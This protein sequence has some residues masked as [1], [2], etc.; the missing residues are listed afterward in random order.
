MKRRRRKPSVLKRLDIIRGIRRV[1]GLRVPS[2]RDYLNKRELTHL[3]A[4][5]SSR[6]EKARAK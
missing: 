2:R 5:M 1:S 4:W 6:E 3:L